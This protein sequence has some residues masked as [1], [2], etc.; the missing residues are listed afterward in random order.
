MFDKDKVKKG[1]L[2]SLISLRRTG[3]LEAIPV[4]NIKHPEWYTSTLPSWSEKFRKE[5][6]KR[7]EV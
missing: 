4:S 1:L 7:K 6:A 3:K 2:L 5:I